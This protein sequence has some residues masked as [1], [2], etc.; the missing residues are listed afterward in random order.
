MKFE[1]ELGRPA[2]SDRIVRECAN[3]GVLFAVGFPRYRAIDNNSGFQLFIAT[4][5]GNDERPPGISVL[6]K[7]GVQLVVGAYS[8]F[9][10]NLE[11]ELVENYSIRSMKGPLCRRASIDELLSILES[12]WSA[13]TRKSFKRVRATTVNLRSDFKGCE[14]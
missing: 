1:I 9:T 14:A 2:E 11:G 3:V 10:R 6:Y 13:Y 4:V 8:T 7:D 12:G 5:E